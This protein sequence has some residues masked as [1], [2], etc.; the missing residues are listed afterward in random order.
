MVQVWIRGPALVIIAA[1]C[2]LQMFV[3]AD[4]Y[5]SVPVHLV[6]RWHASRGSLT[7][8]VIISL[9]LPCHKD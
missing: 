9:R 8:K 5:G 3:Q 4:F 2:W 6:V 1:L 7:W